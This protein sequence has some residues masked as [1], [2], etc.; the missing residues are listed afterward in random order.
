M[1]AINVARQK[2]FRV[3]PSFV[4]KKKMDEKKADSVN[5]QQ[6]KYKK[7]WTMPFQ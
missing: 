3:K 1:N 7:L 6:K 4:D 2:H 5:Y